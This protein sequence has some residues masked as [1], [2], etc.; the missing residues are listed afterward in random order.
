[1]EPIFVTAPNL[2]E[3]LDVSV[4]TT[5]SAHDSAT[6]ALESRIDV[7]VKSGYAIIK[8][9][10]VPEWIEPWGFLKD[11]GGYVFGA[12]RADASRYEL[13]LYR[14]SGMGPVVE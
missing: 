11:G 14:L 8:V 3:G 4:S 12:G 5:T 13:Q 7:R 1:M 6:V 2:P 10:E 9:G